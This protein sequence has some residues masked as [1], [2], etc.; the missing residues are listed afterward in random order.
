MAIQQK[1]KA[2][3]ACS[4]CQDPAIN[5]C[6]SCEIFMCKKCSESHDSWIAIMKLSHNVLSVQE[7]SNPESQVKMRR[8]L[9]CAKHEDKILE[10]YCETCKELCCIDC[11]VLNHQKPNHSCVAM[12]KITEK[13][14][15]T[16]Q[17]S[18]TTLDEKLAE[19]KEVLNNIC[20][21]MKS[22][23]KNAKTAK[24]QIKQ[25]K[26]NILKI[27]AEKLDRK[28]EKMNE[29]VDKVYGE[30]HSELSKQHDEM[31]GYLDKVQA[32]VSLPRNLLKRGSIEEMLSSQKLIDE[33]IEKLSNQQPENLVAVNDDS[34]Q[35]VPDDIGNINVDEIVDK[36][37]HVEGSVSAMC[38]LKKSSSILKGEI[39]FVKQLQK[40]LGEK[41]KWNLCYRASRDGWRANDFHKH[42]DNKGPT[43]VLV[44]AND[45]IF[46]GYTDQNWDSGM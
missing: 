2:S 20:E 36:L 45:C 8:K 43:V 31:K 13:Q 7:L 28:A 26:E 33:K 37:G 30:L 29:E 44:K 46:G 18:C 27:V 32:S 9:Y 38:N 19:G 25:Q 22:L 24:D 21:V 5:H 42:C 1:A 15:E 17:S 16:L 11:V 34:I 14:R 40:W 6:A 23:E 3:T 41:C 12:R 35:Y 4:R 39:A 10:Y